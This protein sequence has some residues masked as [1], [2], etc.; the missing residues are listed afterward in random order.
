MEALSWIRIWG[1]TTTKNVLPTANLWGGICLSYDSYSVSLSLLLSSKIM[2][3]TVKK[4]EPQV[5]CVPKP[6]QP[7]RLSEARST[8]LP[9]LQWGSQRH[10]F[11][12]KIYVD[13]RFVNAFLR[14]SMTSMDLTT[15]KNR[16][17]PFIQV[18]FIHSC[19][20]TWER[21]KSVFSLLL[22]LVAW[23]HSSLAYP[24]SHL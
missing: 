11:E 3:F 5:F 13:K 2:Y 9:H 20:E 8:R 14:F 19:F 1:R 4:E 17:Q 16:P 7:L 6:I 22:K 15:I 12:V 23:W 21:Y 24:S 18:T 10:R